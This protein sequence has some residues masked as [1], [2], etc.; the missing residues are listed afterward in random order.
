MSKAKNYID[1]LLTETFYDATEN[2]DEL[3][4]DWYGDD[5]SL[6]NIDDPDL[7]IAARSLTRYIQF[8]G[9][10]AYPPLTSYE[11]L[12]R[13][14]DALLD[15]HSNLLEEYAILRDEKAQLAETC[16]C[17]RRRIFSTK[18]KGGCGSAKERRRLKNDEMSA[19]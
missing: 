16:R 19:A 11:K 12:R 3:L 2:L 1:A 17:L 13:K 5:L 10:A 15:V 14:Y 4:R 7:S 9:T 8:W 18:I 6:F